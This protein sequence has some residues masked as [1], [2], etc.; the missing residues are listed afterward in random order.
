MTQHSPDISREYL[1][2]RTQTQ[3]D[4]LFETRPDARVLPTARVAEVLE[5]LKVRLI[6]AMD[7]LRSKLAKVLQETLWSFLRSSPVFVLI[8]EEISESLIHD[9]VK[10]HLEDGGFLSDDFLSGDYSAATD[11]L[12]ILFSKTVL[13]VILDH[14]HPDDVPFRDQIASVLL[15]QVI[16]Y[17]GWT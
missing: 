8:G 11:G 7:A 15:E 14:L 1:P 12:N 5:P 13:S 6:T 2:L 4:E 16:V 9:L 17:P 3:L 10:R